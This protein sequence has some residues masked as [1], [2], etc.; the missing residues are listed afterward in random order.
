MVEM[1]EKVSKE[2]ERK[3]SY[4]FFGNIGVWNKFI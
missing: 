1:D 2:N 4:P 3:R